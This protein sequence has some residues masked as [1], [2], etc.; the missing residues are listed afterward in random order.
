MITM[1]ET[2]LSLCSKLSGYGLNALQSQAVRDNETIVN[3]LADFLSV[4]ISK[5]SLT[6]KYCDETDDFLR[7]TYD[8]DDEWI[9]DVC[10]YIRRI[11]FSTVVFDY[12]YEKRTGKLLFYKVWL[13]SGNK[14]TMLKRV[15]RLCPLG[16]FKQKTHKLKTVW[17]GNVA[18]S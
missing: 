1:K 12:C 15:S 9:T 13:I 7:K 6:V 5:D 2:A 4:V 16:L 17:S 18:T 3:V 11:V 14:R 10:D 8:S